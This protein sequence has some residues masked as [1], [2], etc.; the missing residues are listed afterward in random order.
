MVLSQRPSLV[1]EL[2]LLAF[3][4]HVAKLAGFKNLATVF[5]FDVLGV[6]IA[7]DNADSGVGARCVH[8]IVVTEKE[9]FRSDCTHSGR[10]LKHFFVAAIEG[11]QFFALR[12]ASLMILQ[13]G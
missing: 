10:N 11:A 12:G 1:L 7:G 8:G 2:V 13:I 5:A 3:D 4:L 6:L 9:E